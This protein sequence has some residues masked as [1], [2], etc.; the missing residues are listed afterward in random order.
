MP[1][2]PPS[3]VEPLGDAAFVVRLGI[4]ADAATIARVSAARDRVAAG[5]PTGVTDVAATFTT[6]AVFFDPARA[7][8]GAIADALRE[9]LGN[10]DDTPVAPSETVEIPVEYGGLVGPDLD[11]VAEAARLPPAEVVRLHVEARHVVGMIG[12][13]PGFPYL[14]GLPDPLNLPRRPVPRASVPAGSVAVAAGMTGIYPRPGPGGWHVIGRTPT[15][16]FDPALAAPALLRAGD[17]VRFVPSDRGS[18]AVAARAPHPLEGPAGAGSMI[19]RAA[20]GAMT[21]QDGGRFGWRGAGVGPGGMSDRLAF[22][23]ASI[24]VENVRGAAALEWSAF[25]PRLE[26]L[27]GAWIAL[28]GAPFDARVIVPGA[29]DVALPWLHAAWMPSGATLVIGATA[30]GPGRD[31]ARGLCGT[32]AVSGG[33]DVPTVLGSRSTDLRSGFGGLG[34]RTIRAGDRLATGLATRPPPADPG[35]VA[36]LPRTVGPEFTAIGA[37]TT[38]LRVVPGPEVGLFAP[39]AVKLL[40]TATFDVASDSDRM[41][42]RL[43]GPALGSPAGILSEAVAAGTV[44][45]PPGGQ[46]ILLGVDHPVTGGYARIAVVATVDLPVVGQLR[47]GDRVRFAWIGI[48]EARRLARRRALDLDRL[49]VGWGMA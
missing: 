10:V 17:T 16:L 5:L 1:V 30:P 27:S 2:V 26:F 35:R 43:A 4:A 25:G 37:M 24:L 13:T 19:V 28:A 31:S 46:P 18:S 45:V 42:L 44:Q 9:C 34:G 36:I 15:R 22:D 33:I 38:V 29:D 12:F 6:I 21:V 7:D 40:A 14:L 47:P 39:E 32:L 41:G 48:D 49:R 8:A 20:G 3:S 11:A 23:V